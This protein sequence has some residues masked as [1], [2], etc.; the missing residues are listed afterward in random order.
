MMQPKIVAATEATDDLN[1]SFDNANSTFEDASQTFA[2]ALENGLVN[3]SRQG[4]AAFRDMADFIIA[5]IN[6]M[7]IRWVMF[8]TFT[9]L[10]GFFGG[11]FGRA[12]SLCRTIQIAKS[13]QKKTHSH[14]K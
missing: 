8:K 1:D 14:L 12:Y 13:C 6:R 3:A 10:G 9:S 5:E 4:K 7:L 11:S 2:M